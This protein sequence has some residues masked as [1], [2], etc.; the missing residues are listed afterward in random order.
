MND[1]HVTVV[2]ETCESMG[3]LKVPGSFLVDTFPILR[4]LP[5]WMP[6]ASHHKFAQVHRPK[7]EAMVETPF[8]MVKEDIVSAI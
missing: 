5:T 3:M 2:K 8:I 7:V 4:M 6:G 1:P